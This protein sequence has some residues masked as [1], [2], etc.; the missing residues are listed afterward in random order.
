MSAH[1]DTLSPLTAPTAETDSTSGSTDAKLEMAVLAS[2]LVLGTLRT[3]N[4]ISDNSYFTQMS[5]G[6]FALDTG[7]FP[8]TDIWTDSPG[9]WI[10]PGRLSSIFFAVSDTVSSGA[11]GRVVAT[12]TLCG[13]ILI[14]WKLL[15]S[16]D[17]IPKAAISTLFVLG[18]MPFVTQRAQT[19]GLF[20][21][22]LVL[23]LIRDRR[24]TWLLA[25]CPVF[26]FWVNWHG[27]WSLGLAVFVTA[28]VVYRLPMPA[29]LAAGA[30]VAGA[31]ASP[32]GL[33]LLSVPFHHIG[34]SNLS[35]IIEWRHPSLGDQQTLV[36]I[37]LWAFALV[38]VVQRYKSMTLERLVLSVGFAVVFLVASYSAQRNIMFAL[39]LAIW[40]VSEARREGKA[41]TKVE[42]TERATL[43]TSLAVMAGLCVLIFATSS[44]NF[45]SAPAE[46]V[47]QIS[48][49]RTVLT[50]LDTGA[51]IQYER[52]PQV[53]LFVDDRG[54]MHSE[55]KF[56]L[57][58]EFRLGDIS[59]LDS[60]NVDT[61]LWQAE[62]EPFKKLL[63]DPTW[64][65]VGTELRPDGVEMGLAIRA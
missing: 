39:P 2:L 36:F 29:L 52:G 3:W 61:V 9:R 55:E 15:A 8:Q 64:R 7:S 4:A 45:V 19:S 23:Y 24:E 33:D 41:N 38:T 43:K 5:N 22:C 14:V 1:L 63:D 51:F 26:A 40:V 42:P 25:F 27:S 60:M 48:D 62:T 17:L 47:S 20:L 11:L 49:G 12:I 46:L 65:L 44:Y 32:Y 13:A 16:F 10:A 35:Y 54:E 21:F 34:K 59:T 6:L 18:E 37:A 30:T 58:E 57:W 28:M 56:R 31:L 53:Q 50:D